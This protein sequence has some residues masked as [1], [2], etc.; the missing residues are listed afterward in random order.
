MTAVKIILSLCCYHRRCLLTT[1]ENRR[2][3]E[4][5][6]ERVRRSFRFTVCSHARAC[7]SPAQRTA[8]E[9]VQRGTSPLKP[10]D[11]LNG[12]PV[13]KDPVSVRL[14]EHR[15]RAVGNRHSF[16]DGAWVVLD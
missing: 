9:F 13:G 11:G 15:P 12:R 8:R 14:I 3:F 1:D 5:A 4:S 16:D 6:L 2:I 10:K 7:S